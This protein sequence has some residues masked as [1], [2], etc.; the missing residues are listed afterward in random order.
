MGR[1]AQKRETDAKVVLLLRNDLCSHNHWSHRSGDPLP[2]QLNGHV[3][4]KTWTR[5]IGELEL[6]LPQRGCFE[7][8]CP[9]VAA[10]AGFLILLSADCATVHEEADGSASGEYR[11]WLTGAPSTAV[12]GGTIKDDF[13]KSDA[14]GFGCANQSDILLGLV[15]LGLMVASALIFGFVHYHRR[16]HMRD[17]LIGIA[18]KHRDAMQSHGIVLTAG[19]ARGYMCQAEQQ[20]YLRL[21]VL[22]LPPVNA[23]A[24][25]GG[26][27]TPTTPQ[28]KHWTEQEQDQ[29]LQPAQGKTIVITI[30]ESAQ[31]GETISVNVPG[32]QVLAVVVPHDL[33]AGRTMKMTV[34]AT[35]VVN[36]HPAVAVTTQPIAITT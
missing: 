20:H 7:R 31:P 10:V 4:L 17:T 14:G 16:Q 25:G 9:L 6:A 27:E 34:N 30:P 8:W 5:F 21:N 15:G 13:D 2:Y 1:H 3:D 28:R 33:A 11:H 24:T 22:P 32:G 26:W 29:L 19:H 23:P 18:R 35:R 36:E 12:S